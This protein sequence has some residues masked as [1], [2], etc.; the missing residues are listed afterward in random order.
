MET[1]RQVHFHDFFRGLQQQL[2]AKSSMREAIE[3]TLQD[4]L[5]GTELFFFDELHVQDPASAVLLN[6]LLA[7]RRK[8]YPHADH[9]EL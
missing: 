8:R 4:L 7:D 2:G 9:L 6:R 5:T 3:V 1:K